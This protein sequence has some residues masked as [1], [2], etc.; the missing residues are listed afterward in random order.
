[1]KG[2][3][4]AGGNG[5]RLGSLT[6]VANK[7]SLP[8]FKM[9]MIFYPINT[10][11]DAGVKDIMIVV[12]GNNPSDF[13]SLIGDGSELGVNITFRFQNR[14]DGIPGALKLARDFVGDDDCLVILGDN[15]I[16]G[17]IKDEVYKFE[18]E[19]QEDHGARC[20]LKEV[21]DPERFGVAEVKGNKI[22]SLEEKPKRPKSN[23]AV[24]GI[25]MFDYNV[26]GICDGLSKSSRGEYEITDVNREY[27]RQG[28]L[29]WG[30]LPGWWMD[31][32]TPES[33]YLASKQ[34][35]E[36][37]LNGN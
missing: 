11:R 31:A 22:V 27:L 20:L 19:A 7:H 34:V 3:I 8:I 15:I 6:K 33:L 10:L 37:Y 36:D 18:C 5:T 23:Y 13:M 26:F 30:T 9:P 28:K 29:S 14:P 17:N 32:G 35:Y 24:T 12:G 1:M 4:L 2:V 16:G 25:Y 21:H